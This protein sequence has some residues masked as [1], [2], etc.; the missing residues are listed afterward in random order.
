[1]ESS[2]SPG[3]QVDPS[4]TR[5]VISRQAYWINS[6]LQRLKSDR[7]ILL[8]YSK[9]FKGERVPLASDE[10]FRN[11]WKFR[12]DG[13]GRV[14]GRQIM[15]N[16]IVLEL[17]SDDWTVQADEGEKLRGYL[18]KQGVPHVMG[19]SGNKGLHFHIFLDDTKL[20]SIIGEFEI[21]E[22]V[23]RYRFARVMM[24]NI[25]IKNS[26]VSDKAKVDFSRITWN[27]SAQGQLIR[28]F[29]CLRDNGQSKTLIT[30][31]PKEKPKFGSL[32]LIIPQDVKPWGME[33]FEGKLEEGY[34]KEVKRAEKWVSEPLTVQ[35]PIEDVPCLNAM[36]L[37]R[38]E[39]QRHNGAFSIVHTLALMGK[40]KKEAFEVLQRYAKAC[41]DDDDFKREVEESVASLY[42]DGTPKLKIQKPLCNRIRQDMGEAV[43]NRKECLFFR[44]YEDSKVKK[45]MKNSDRP[46]VEGGY[47]ERKEKPK[48]IDQ[49]T[50]I[51]L[52]AIESGAIFF[53]DERNEPHANI[54]LVN[55]GR[56]N[57]AFDDKGFSDW[58]AYQYYKVE[59]KAPTGTV[60]GDAM[61]TLRGKA[62]FEGEQWPLSVRAAEYEGVF[63]YD[64]CDP[65]GKA[66]MIT[67]EGWQIVEP[68]I[69]FR[70]Y[71][72]MKPQVEPSRGC[73]VLDRFIKLWRLASDDDATMLKII[74][75]SYFIPDIVRPAVALHG[76]PGS[77]KSTLAKMI[78]IVIDPSEIVNPPL[79]G[80]EEE[81]L[82][83]LSRHYLNTFDNVR[84]MKDWQSDLLCVAVT[85]G[86]T[87]KRALWRNGDDWIMKI[88]TG[89]ILT[90][91]NLEITEPDLLD[92]SLPLELARIP[93]DERR[94]DAEVMG[95][96]QAMLPGL[97][98]ELLDHVSSAMRIKASKKITKHPR[99]A[100]W[101][102]W[103]ICLSESMGIGEVEFNRIFGKFIERQSTFAIEN[104][105]LATTILDVLQTTTKGYILG[106]PARLLEYLSMQAE[107]GHTNIK[108]KGWPKD[109]PRFGKELN[110]IKSNLAQNGIQVIDCNYRDIREIIEK[111]KI[112]MIGDKT[113]E[114]KMVK[115]RDEDRIKIIAR[116]LEPF[117]TVKNFKT[118]EI[119]SWDSTVSPSQSSEKNS[120]TVKQ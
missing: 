18:E 83:M 74:L 73:N 120:K 102:S 47:D 4:D 82:R 108:S 110:K 88:K 63:Y 54:P 65:S 13:D 40:S 95:E 116:N 25:L 9:N 97:I 51:I 98:G 17:D 46:S 90:G 32:P 27:S 21:D 112:D 39:G 26:G 55:G 33:G 75:A 28:E 6:V 53:H 59:G 103:A 105:I 78:K 71:E 38:P 119:E 48:L 41:G 70:R 80:R 92:R 93:G 42:G 114:G 117:K 77:T 72:H 20:R 12:Y 100:E 7:P 107:S 36:L 109:P 85:G 87:A 30:E 50:R 62:R 60:L 49:V 16:E 68:P 104:A 10:W 67:P 19:Y 106:T 8:S 118:V 2:I 34:Q 101:Y 24:A 58:I 37:G 86:S 56:I 79:P 1:M 69:I 66:V 81:L 76:P 99:M 96:I 3:V 35:G 31:I 89:V 29:G 5:T 14:Y 44:K 61:L 94:E 115:Y 64:L 45:E 11:N 52:Q 22:Q 15:L 113:I 91:V 23:D 111:L 84:D 43:C 57:L